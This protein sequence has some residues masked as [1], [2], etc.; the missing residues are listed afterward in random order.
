M[1]NQR[2]QIWVTTSEGKT[3]MAF[4]WTRDPSSGIARAKSEGKAFGHD[5]VDAWSIGI[6]DE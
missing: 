4:I 1:S 6:E 2:Y 3:F 5:I